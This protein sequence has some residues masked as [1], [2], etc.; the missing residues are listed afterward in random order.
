MDL[1]NFSGEDEN[2]SQTEA[3]TQIAGINVKNKMAGEWEKISP[4]ST[5]AIRSKWAKPMAQ[6]PDYDKTMENKAQEPLKKL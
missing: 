1:K 3:L 6:G 4:I 2:D 5:H